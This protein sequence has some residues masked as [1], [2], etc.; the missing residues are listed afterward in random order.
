MAAGA[1]GLGQ[2][3]DDLLRDA[4]HDLALV[5]ARE[6]LPE[7][8]EAVQGGAAFDH[9]AARIALGFDERRFRAL[10]RGG[11]GRYHARGAASGDHHIEFAYRQFARGFLVGIVRGGSTGEREQTLGEAAAVHHVR[12]IA[13]QRRDTATSLNQTTSPGS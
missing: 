12:M 4:A 1:A 7:V 9:G 13:V 3:L 8:V 2:P 11:D 10:A 5:Y 6:S